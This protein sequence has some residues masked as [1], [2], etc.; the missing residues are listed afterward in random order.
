MYT[1]LTRK[2]TNMKKGSK[3][4]Y[5]V[6]QEFE[7]WVRS[8]YLNCPCIFDKEKGDTAGYFYCHGEVNNEFRAFLC[9][10]QLGRIL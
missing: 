9:G 3:E 4:F 1:L 2:E 7:K 5:N 8:G 10:F 6:M